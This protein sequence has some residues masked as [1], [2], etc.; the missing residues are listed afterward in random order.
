MFQFTV[1]CILILRTS[2]AKETIGITI[3]SGA[4]FNE[5]SEAIMYDKSI[6]LIYTQKVIIEENSFSE[7]LME[8][9]KYCKNKNTSYCDT[10][11]QSSSLLN[12]LNININK[13]KKNM[14]KLEEINNLYNKKTI[15][16]KRGIQFI[17]DFYNFCCDIATEKQIKHFYTNEEK[18]KKQADK[19]RDVFVSDHKDLNTITTQLNNYTTLTENKLE[20]LKGSLK[21]FFE[22]EKKNQLL[23][24]ST[25]D[26]EIRGVQETIFYLTTSLLKFINYERESSTHLHCKIGKIPPRLIDIDI[27]Y[28]D[29]SN[30]TKILQ[31]D[32]FELVIQIDNLS[33]YYNIPITEC[34]FSKTEILVKIKIPIQ[35]IK[36]NWELF[37]Y[38]PAHFKFRNSTCIIY[39]EKT[40]VARNTINKEHRIISGMGLQ[41][42]DPPVTDLC[43]IPKF[44]SDI[45][46]TPKCVESIYKNLPINEI[47]KYCYFQCV[48]QDGNDETIIKQIGV[49]TFSITNPQPT[50][51]IKNGVGETTDIQELNIDYEHPGLI[52]IKLPCDHEVLENKKVIIP[53]MYPCEISNT[54]KLTIHRVLPISWTNLKSL[55]ILHEEKKDKILFSNLTEILNHDWKKDIPNFHI[56]KQIKDPK[57]YFKETILEN[58]PNK[59][60]SD[61]LGDIIYMTWLTILTLTIAFMCYKIYPVIV[62]VRV[63]MVAH[64]LPP[65]IPSR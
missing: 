17:G 5:I 29:L 53:K 26:K 32:G 4:F 37:Q 30:L 34:Q 40:Y 61:F 49:N 13:N 7:N 3:S 12:T 10:L 62:T 52:K 63:L 9:E 21:I 48:T 22:E 33:A 56:N 8:V 2:D 39:S 36:T 20:I 24:I 41:H 55:I 45:S 42:C 6:P 23:E 47:N 59:L 43:Y 14:E 38:I 64:Q 11:R 19:L 50:L 31:K 60:I 28:N 51:F 44:S 65:P 27:L 57:E 46:L 54:N 16:S 25:I 35:E 1:I 15:R 58:M 18:L